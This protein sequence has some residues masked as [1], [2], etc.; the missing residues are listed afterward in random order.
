DGL[1]EVDFGDWEGLT[2]AEVQQRYPD[3][4]DAWLEAPAEGAPPPDG[5]GAWGVPVPEG[6][7]EPDSAPRPFGLLPP[8][9]LP[10]PL[11]RL[12]S[13]SSPSP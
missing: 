3:D 12:P 1:R 13:R 11:P 7:G 10:F 5:A 8:L 6:R 4:L 9:P 2:F